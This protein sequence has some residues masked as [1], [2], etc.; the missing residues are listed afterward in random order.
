MASQTNTKDN[1]VVYIVVDFENKNMQDIEKEIT[2][3]VNKYIGTEIDAIR[4]T[5]SDY[6]YKILIRKMEVQKQ[7]MLKQ[8]ILQIHA[9]K[10][11]KARTKEL[12]AMEI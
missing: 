3:R 12:I 4:N 8:F 7:A 2:D 1:S 6:E 10:E 11:I 9:R 5:L